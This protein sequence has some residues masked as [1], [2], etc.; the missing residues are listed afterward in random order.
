MVHSVAKSRTRLKQLSAHARKHTM[1]DVN[2]AEPVLS[3]GLHQPPSLQQ[4]SP[5][6]QKPPKIRAK[7]ALAWQKVLLVS[8]QSYEPLLWTASL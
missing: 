5:R 1:A 6:G 4:K 2:D 7:V 3:T 8:G